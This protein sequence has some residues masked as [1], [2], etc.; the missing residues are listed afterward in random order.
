MGR[1]ELAVDL[2][3]VKIRFGDFTAVKSMNL[4]VAET[5]FVAVVGRP[6][7]ENRPFSTLS[8]DC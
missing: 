5:E 1:P 7:V 8:P 3:E 2:H 6:A 4:Q